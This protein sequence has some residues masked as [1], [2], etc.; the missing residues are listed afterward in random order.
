MASSQTMKIDMHVHT[1]EGSP[2]AKLPAR[3]HVRL[4]RQAGFGAIVI[5]EHVWENYP[6]LPMPQR[7]EQWTAGYREAKAEGDA[8]GLKVFLG[9]EVRLCRCGGADCLVYGLE[10]TDVAWLLGTLDTAQSYAELSQAVREKGFFFAQAHPFRVGYQ[11]LDP[12]ILDGAE[13]YNG[14]PRGN[15]NNNELAFA[16]AAENRLVMISGSDAHQ[17][18]DVAHGG[19]QIPGEIETS[20]QLCAWLKAGSLRERENFL[21]SVVRL[22]EEKKEENQ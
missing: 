1:M 3:E 10:L 21:C 4:Y 13:A 16:F 9:A 12:A 22:P 6:D 2:D 5:T 19:L 14:K 17:A 18:I 8:A 15:E 20:A 11:P 7:V